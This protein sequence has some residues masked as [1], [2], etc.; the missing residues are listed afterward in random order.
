MSF[1]DVLV[2]CL[3]KFI[4]LFLY[5]YCLLITGHQFRAHKA[6]LAACSQFFH[7]FFQDFNQEPLVEIEG[8]KYTKIC[9]HTLI[10]ILIR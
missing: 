7:R 8:I 3:C 5:L 1:H 9:N 2:K 6:V 10:I 4:Y